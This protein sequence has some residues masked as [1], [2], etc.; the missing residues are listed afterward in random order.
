[1]Y[2]YYIKTALTSE[3]NAGLSISALTEKRQGFGNHNHHATGPAIY[4]LG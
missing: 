2:A 4:K 3:I 1:M